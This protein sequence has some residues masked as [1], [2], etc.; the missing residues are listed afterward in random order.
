MPFH[1]LSASAILLCLLAT[2]A[3]AAPTACFTP[4]E[5]KAANFRTLQ[6]DLTVAALNCQSVDP[7]DKT[8]S[9]RDRYNGFVSRFG[10][11]LQDNAR[12]V[13]NHFTRTR[14]NFDQWMT[15]VAND[16]G[17]R[18]MTDGM[19]CQRA[20]DTLDKALTLPPQELPEFVGGTVQNATLV[21]LCPETP[22]A[23][24][25]KTKAKAKKSTSKSS[26]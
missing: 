21:S 19:F 12:L 7:N 17:Q 25:K 8:P 23:P 22:P 2:S 16:A 13:K 5:A 1:R 15:Q 3:Q 18:V 9:I 14:G 11:L 26:S 6:Q 10:D 4:D 24:E 20:A